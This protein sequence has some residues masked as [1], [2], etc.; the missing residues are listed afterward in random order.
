MTEAIVRRVRDD[1]RALVAL[2]VLLAALS[3]AAILPGLADADTVAE[4]DA[5]LRIDGADAPGAV[6]AGSNV[7]VEVAVTDPDGQPVSDLGVG[8]QLVA[9][10]AARRIDIDWDTSP[11]T[12]DTDGV[13]RWDVELTRAGLMDLVVLIEDGSGFVSG[14]ELASVEVAVEPGPTTAIG[15]VP[16]D[17][18]TLDPTQDSYAFGRPVLRF[19]DADDPVE[20]ISA[21]TVDAY[22]NATAG[23][24]DELAIDAGPV[25]FE[26]EPGGS[27]PE[28][29]EADLRFDR[30]DED[31]LAWPVDLRAATDDDPLQ[32]IVHVSDDSRA[33]DST[34]VVRVNP[35]DQD[36]DVVDDACLELESVEDGTAYGQDERTA[37][38][39][40]FVPGGD[41]LVSLYGCGGVLFEETFWPGTTDR[42]AAQAVTV[43]AYEVED[44]GDLAIDVVSPATISGTLTTEL[45]ASTDLSTVCVTLVGTDRSTTP[46]APDGSFAV[47]WTGSDDPK[48]WFA[49]CGGD[50][51]PTAELIPAYHDGALDLDQ[52]QAVEV[53]RG[54]ETAIETVPL[55]IG[56][57]IEV[58]VTDGDE[59]VVEQACVEGWT[60]AWLDGL[61]TASTGDD[62]SATLRGLP[63][64][65]YRVL[66]RDCS[67]TEMRF[68]ETYMPSS[69]GPGGAQLIEVVAGDMTSAAIEVLPLA[70]VTGT[71]TVAEEL[72]QAE[73]VCLAAFPVDESSAPRVCSDG[74]GPFDYTIDVPAVAHH[75]RASA[76]PAGD[77]TYRWFF[78]IEDPT[79]V[80]SRS[81]ATVVEPSAGGTL[82]GMDIVLDEADGSGPADP[83][84][85][86][87]TLIE[88]P[89]ELVSGEQAQLSV[90]VATSSGEPAEGEVELSVDE[91]R[92]SVATLDADGAA[93]LDVQLFDPGEVTLEVGYLGSDE[94]AAVV[95]THT[96]EVLP[97]ST[98]L[99]LDPAGPL[100]VDPDETIAIEATVAVLS[101]GSGVP[102]GDVEVTGLP[103]DTVIPLE[104][105][106][107]AAAMR[108]DVKG[109]QPGDHTLGFRYLGDSNREASDPE[110]L[111]VTVRSPADIQVMFDPAQP[112]VGQATQVEVDVTSESTGEAVDSAL[113]LRLDG[114]PI[115]VTSP[116]TGTFLASIVPEEAGTR[117][118][119]ATVTSNDDD[120]VATTT[121]DV[122][123][124]V[125]PAS[126]ETSLE[127]PEVID[128]TDDPTARIN[129][130]ALAPGGG[131]PTGQVT[132]SRPGDDGERILVATG[133]LGDDDVSAADTSATSL[134]GV[135]LELGDLP[136][137]RH[138]LRADYEGSADHRSSSS[139]LVTVA[140]R[141]AT[142]LE[143]HLPETPPAYGET[144]EVDLELR[145]SGDLSPPAEASVTVQVDGG[146]A[147]A[148]ELTDGSG[149]LSLPGGE[150]I[151][152]GARTLDAAF[153]GDGT[154]APSDGSSTLEVVPAPT[155]V[156]VDGPAGAVSELRPIEL[157]AQVEATRGSETPAGTLIVTE[158]DGDEL[159]RTQVDDGQHI[160][161]LEDLPPGERQLEVSFEPD[162]DPQRF[163]ASG[164]APVS[165]E[166]LSSVTTT[167]MELPDGSAVAGQPVEVAVIVDPEAEG[168]RPAS[169]QVRL[170]LFAPD[171]D[172]PISLDPRGLDDQGAVTIGIPPLYL[173]AIGTWEVSAQYLG[174][175]DRAPSSD[176]GDLALDPATTSI[177]APSELTL[178]E[179]EPL[180]V[181]VEVSADAPSTR[182]PT[183]AI[184]LHDD[185]EVLASTE[186]VGGDATI[187][188]QDLEV[189]A[190]PLD[191]VYVP[192]DELYLGQSR[193]LEVEVSELPPLELDV[194][195]QRLEDQASAE[196]TVTVEVAGGVDPVTWVL[197]A[198]DGREP[199]EGEGREASRTLTY[200]PGEYRLRV[201]AIDDR[202]EDE[203]VAVSRQIEVAE[204][205]EP[206]V[207]RAG[208]DRA[209][210][211]DEVIALDGSTST[212][213]AGAVDYR[214]DLGDGRTLEGDRVEASWPTAGTYDVTLT[215]DDGERQ[216]DDTVEVQVEEPAPESV[217]VSV[218]VD[219]G[220]PIPGAEVVAVEADGTIRSATADGEGVAR[221]GGLDDGPIRVAAYA[222]GYRP[223][224]GEV[225]VIDGAGEVTVALEAGDLLEADLEATR[226]SEDEAA[227]LGV[228]LEDDDNQLIWEV[229]ARLLV[230]G[231]SLGVPT[232]RDDN[233]V[234]VQRGDGGIEWHNTPDDTTCN[235]DGTCTI[236]TP[237]HRIYRSVSGGG[238]WFGDGGAAPTLT[239]LVIPIEGRILKEFFDVHLEVANLA[240]SGFDLLDIDA[241]I[242]LPEGL[243]LAALVQGEQ[244]TT[245]ELGTIP[246]GGT[247][248][249]SWIVRGD[250]SG[251]YDL[252]ATAQGQLA[253][254][255]SPVEIEAI[256]QDPIRIWG[257]DA[258]RFYV[259]ADEAVAS[260]SPYN[261]RLGLEN[262]SDIDVYGAQLTFLEET[263]NV[264][265]QPR[266]QRGYRLGTIAPG[267]TAWTD[268]ATLVPSVTGWID[269]DGSYVATVAGVAPPAEI[270]TQPVVQPVEELLDIT[271]SSRS[272]YHLVRYEEDPAASDSQLF[273]TD[274]LDTQF[275]TTPVPLASVDLPDDLVAIDRDEVDWG[276]LA[277]SSTVEGRPALRHR[278]RPIGLNVGA[279]PQARIRFTDGAATMCGEPAT[280]VGQLTDPL[281]ELQ[282]Y[283]IRIGDGEPQRHSVSGSEATTA[284]Y[285]FN[286]GTGTGADQ[287]GP[288]G[289]R[290]SIR[291]VD[292]IDNVGRWT[293]I[294][295]RPDCP[296]RDVAVLA[297]GLFSSL[298]DGDDYHA[299]LFGTPDDAPHESVVGL[300]TDLGYDLG[301]DGTGDRAA[302]N[303]TIIEYSYHG[304]SVS[305][306][307]NGPT[308]VPRDYRRRD[309]V[310]RVT[311]LAS[312]AIADTIASGG[313]LV[314]TR[315]FQR[316]Q[317]REFLS[318]LVDYDRAWNEHHDEWLRFNMIGHSLG[319]RQILEVALEAQLRADACEAG[320]GHVLDGYPCQRY[321]ELIGAV[322]SVSGA[323]YPSAIGRDINPVSCV[324]STDLRL[325][326]LP[327]NLAVWPLS[328]GVR[329]V[330]AAAHLAQQFVINEELLVA[331][332][333]GDGIDTIAT[334]KDRC[335]SLNAT[336]ADEG[337]GIGRSSHWVSSEG[338][339][340]HAAL[341]TGG[342]PDGPG[343]YQP[344]MQLL[345]QQ[346]T[347]TDPVV[348]AA[349]GSLS[350]AS[351]DGAAPQLSRT[352]SQTMLQARIA[353]ASTDPSN[354]SQ[355][356]AVGDD[357]APVVLDADPDGEVDVPLPPGTYRFFVSPR[358]DGLTGAWIGGENPSDARRYELGAGETVELGTL[359]G[360]PL[361]ELQVE[362]QDTSGAA[363]PGAAALLLDQDGSPVAFAETDGSGETRLEQVL[364][365]DY[366]LQVGGIGWETRQVPISVPTGDVAALEL[367]PA[368]STVVE[369]E[370]EQDGRPLAGVVIELADDQGT[371]VGAGVTD[372]LGTAVITDLPDGELVGTF[373]DPGNLHDLDTAS[374][375]LTA[376]RGSVAEIRQS[377]A[378][379]TGF[380]PDDGGTDDP[381]DGGSGDGSGSGGSGSPSDPQ[382][383]GGAGGDSVDEDPDRIAAD[384]WPTCAQVSPVTFEDLDPDAT[385]GDNVGC[386]GA[387][388]IL[389]G[390]D[391]SQFAPDLPMRRDQFATILYR[392][393]S[394]SG[395]EFDQAPIT[396]EDVEGIHATAIGELAAAGVIEG[397]STERFDPDAEITRG[398]MLTLLSRTSDRFGRPFPDA[399]R[400]P[401]SDVSATVHADAI[402]RGHAAG[403]AQGYED[404]TFR[405]GEYVS[406]A[407]AASLTVR[408]LDWTA[409][410][411]DGG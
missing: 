110:T 70:K 343:D 326:E 15:I 294:T 308:F 98:S 303:R 285:T 366:L 229:E 356:V 43:E 104:A 30:P 253:L 225:D 287:V 192:D 259:E 389:R 314:D 248:G 385:H 280:L 26:S 112:V 84:P 144:F 346:L 157:S 135:T 60:D 120:V 258:L 221:L 57:S 312:G 351:A 302:P 58:T 291:A 339:T 111:D 301:H 172:E 13:A 245:V 214:W 95:Q 361:H 29:L 8:L 386:L 321:Q 353:G 52:A 133:E 261:M 338:K 97:A 200:D 268:T 395:V 143:L 179:D 382:D 295:L 137:G 128:P 10:D 341:L 154:L 46:L 47:D 106:G 350:T 67:G 177:D 212:P 107:D 11:R 51:D 162:L 398:Q 145:P 155:A 349:G 197:D 182:I 216:V 42:D 297:A 252:S 277:V 50:D 236:R 210:V 204:P 318:D 342:L 122:D 249:H 189:G 401:F 383:P 319:A 163:A 278:V 317:A 32:G 68:A 99:T 18:V 311:S 85:A 56:G 33:G 79:G 131:T 2:V 181:E 329:G 3:V 24:I 209:T 34:G 151:E 198:G 405:P 262:V 316:W 147:Y 230:R 408:W 271:V 241:S 393:L 409:T 327:A 388:D 279:D 31:R 40:G 74:P 232:V 390:V 331:N 340:A 237:S 263:E 219:A 169:G 156:R 202:G 164:A 174:D 324:T 265:Y 368:S 35:I 243:G 394:G 325:I 217:Q 187:L 334:G 309:T 233:E 387:L 23:P 288:D 360:T 272:K 208:D 142:D 397:R 254:F 335:L 365:G 246:G 180:E 376:S 119:T 274:D 90:V 158:A 392:V 38:L 130:G 290:V 330:S 235:D 377:V 63:A 264:I 406:R 257:V 91:Q 227:G 333:F 108:I 323:V 224:W 300:L 348:T 54:T 228:D 4:L 171:A 100:T 304:A 281:L 292:E 231:G 223:A 196:R 293:T 77:P 354:P 220:G 384:E 207:P 184:E 168:L 176:A 407:Q 105:D 322:T 190:Y 178:A 39:E 352:D 375:T 211:V 116:E 255:G 66:A 195:V 403:L 152:V 88:P 62:G 101:P 355:L 307:S 92:S 134:A 94:A 364:A 282:A 140:V 118:L 226:L 328:L 310:A 127:A 347:A 381:D 374:T 76:D 44:L 357:D 185:G 14:D 396:F 359:E 109:L 136:V 166:V 17:V 65:D 141:A 378:L 96:L 82:P 45:G 400:A 275:P 306:T 256:A 298:S 402:L 269:L 222:E 16:G 267:E 260:R 373:S 148:V 240:A 165:V 80:V 175:A 372:A 61:P 123:L 115:E 313:D 132:V 6:V 72:G 296:G 27:Q 146:S 206:L 273:V 203:A 213:G 239:Y 1:G 266:Q 28:V 201:V 186:L 367:E 320:T 129:V 345:Q 371:V 86:D 242:N 167:S 73:E 284:A 370:S 7:E 315:G 75:L 150:P 305:S 160:F 247:A 369:L 102:T 194:Q 410:V 234:L 19:L 25:S 153:E 276:E 205:T 183:G 21:F 332:R 270:A 71:V 138:D 114:D 244:T 379:T 336:L 9:P 251:S 161:V 87:L 22:G 124:E 117:T 299:E 380:T 37:P 337:L 48:V 411:D 113:E 20:P 64:G 49:H 193:Q 173:D 89:T 289:L 81:D 121:L 283:D 358:A 344:L 103:D 139:E 126:T 218:I 12:T 149:T 191:V 238:G 125:A 399:D 78:S 188:A 5:T 83:E 36:G 59:Q 53:S 41:Y 363:I 159:A 170:D 93:D 286:P 69:P 362:L 404:G 55:Q 391:E 215:L 250:E 199:I